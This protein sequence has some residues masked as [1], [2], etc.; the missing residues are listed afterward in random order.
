LWSVNAIAEDA[1][2]APGGYAEFLRVEAM[3][4]G[5]Y[6]LPR[7]ATDTQTPH[8]ED[9]VYFVVRGRSRFHH[10]DRDDRVGPGDVLFVP[11]REIHRFHSIEEELV[12][13]VLFAPAERPVPPGGPTP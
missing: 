11:A 5:V 13:L 6:V 9:E 3:S 8:G 7:G 12:L 1:R 10:G 4:A 2:R